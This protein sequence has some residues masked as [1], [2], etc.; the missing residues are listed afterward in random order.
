[1]FPKGGLIAEQQDA[2]NGHARLSSLGPALHDE[3]ARD[4][5]FGEGFATRVTTPSPNTPVPNAPILDDQWLG[6]LCD[7]GAAGAVALGPRFVG[8]LRRLRR[9]AKCDPSERSSLLTALAASV[10]GYAV[11]MLTY[12]SFSFIQVTFLLFIFLGLGSAVLQASPSEWPDSPSDA[13]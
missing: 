4:P 8:F 2:A 6:V 3:F 13:V 5:V 10:T 9:E 7:T 1:F 12:D 11:S